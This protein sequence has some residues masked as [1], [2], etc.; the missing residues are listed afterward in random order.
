LRVRNADD[1]GG[2]FPIRATKQLTEELLSLVIAR[3][4]L[5]MLT[6]GDRIHTPRLRLIDRSINPILSAQNAFRGLD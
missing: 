2:H 3:L 1:L 5:A 6:E 4:S